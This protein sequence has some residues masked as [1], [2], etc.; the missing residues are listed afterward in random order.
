MEKRRQGPSVYEC[1]FLEHDDEDRTDWVKLAEIDP[2]AGRVSWYGNYKPFNQTPL[3][4]WKPP[5]R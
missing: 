4:E 3:S 2:A 1:Y 5:Q